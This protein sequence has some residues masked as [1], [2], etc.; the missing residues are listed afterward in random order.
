MYL[1]KLSDKIWQTRNARFNAAKRMKRNH[2]SSTASVALLSASVIT[3]NLLTFIEEMNDSYKAYITIASVI[4]STFALVMSLLISLLRYE[5]RKDNYHQCA[6]ELEALNQLVQIR[7]DELASNSFDV[8]NVVSPKEDN[9]E[10]QG[11]YS[12]IMQKYN[13]NHTIFDWQ[14]GRLSNSD[15]AL[16]WLTKTWLIF[17]MYIWDIYILYWL[18]ALVPIVALSCVLW[19]YFF[20]P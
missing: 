6:M 8:D 20:C 18:I 10:F 13:L 1:K 4:F 16:N 3:V 5:W 14:Y 19:S 17:R 9:L 2:I 11:R 15:N 7:I 12:A